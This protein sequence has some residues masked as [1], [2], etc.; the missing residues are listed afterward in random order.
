MLAIKNAKVITITNGVIDKGTVLI[1]NGKIKAVGTDIEIPAE[2]QIIEAE[3]KYVMPG[4]IDAHTAIGLKEGGMRWEGADHIE[5]TDP[6]LPHLRAVDGFNPEDVALQDAIE[7][8]VTTC[9]VMPG[10]ANVLGGIGFAVKTSGSV[11]DKMVV[12]EVGLKGALGE[13][14]KRMTGG[15]RMPATRMGT[16]AVL[17]QA[18]LKAKSYAKKLEK[19]KENPDKEPDR[20]LKMEAVLKVLNKELPLFVHAHRADDIMTAIRIAKEFDIK[21]VLVH[22]YEAYKVTRYLKEY[23]IPVVYGPNFSA[24]WQVETRNLRED[25]PAV[26][27]QEGIKMAITTSH[28]SK[29]VALLTFCAGLA[30]RDGLCPDEALKAIT[31][32]AAEIMGV[33]DRVG[34]IEPGKDA[35][36]VILDG[37]PLHLMTRV[38]KTIVNGEVVYCGCCCE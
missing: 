4:L 16:A 18:L 1:E 22:A 2:A 24:R 9:G 26:L 7:A 6:V 14:A 27:A 36:L 37:H 33:A 11:V 35:D 29:P 25:T 17:R 15:K 31:I 30:V 21:L 20:N 34:S 12:A 3:G 8:G 10:D 32:N 13:Q 28:P 23:D 38:E 19:A 5:N